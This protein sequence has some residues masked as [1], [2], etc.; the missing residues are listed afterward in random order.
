MHGN[1]FEWC[2]DGYKNYD[3]SGAPQTDPVGDPDYIFRIVRGGCWDDT[4][5]SLRSAF[6]TANAT[7]TRSKTIGF[8]LVRP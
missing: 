4:F 7:I 2:W 1:V 6:R 5:A 8:R 3:P